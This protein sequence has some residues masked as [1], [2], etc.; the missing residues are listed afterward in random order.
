MGARARLSFYLRIALGLAVVVTGSMAGCSGDD[1][2]APFTGGT[3]GSAG[4]PIEAGPCQEGT[5]RP[6]GFPVQRQGDVVSCFRG[7][8]SCQSGT[9]G[10]CANGTVTQERHEPPP[11]GGSRTQALGPSVDCLNNPCDP[12]CKVYNETPDGGLISDVD[13]GVLF[14]WTS[15]SL[16]NV[17]TTL[18][19]KGL[20]QP[21]R[22]G[23]DC[24]FNHRCQD[25][26][27]PQSCGHSKCRTGS[28]LP[29]NCDPCVSMICAQDPSCC[30]SC[31]HSYCVEGTKLDPSCGICVA[32]VCTAMPSCCAAG[33]SWDAACVA[34][35]ATSCPT[36][37][38]SCRP[39]ELEF[40]GKC[41]IELTTGDSWTLSRN[42]CRDR[43]T[44]WDLVTIG[45]QA[46][47]AFVRASASGVETWIGY[48]DSA[49]EGS[50][51]WSNGEAS[52][53]Q[54]WWRHPDGGFNEDCIRIGTSGT[55]E[56]RD[57][58]SGRNSVC[59]KTGT[60]GCTAANIFNGN[61]Y[62]LNTNDLDWQDARTACQNH[63]AG[64]DLVSI[65]DAAENTFVRN[66]YVTGDPAWTGLNDIATENTFVWANGST[67]TYR[68][69]QLIEPNDWDRD[70]AKLLRDPGTLGDAF[71]Y[72]ENCSDDSPNAF[73]EGPKE[74]GWSQACVDRVKTTCDASCSTA[75]PPSRA[76][77]C[78]PWLPGQTD[79][80]CSGFD[81]AIGVPC[82]GGV[83]P[84]C[85]HGTMTAPA[86]VKVI[87]FRKDE[88][89]FGS[90]TPDQALRDD[91]DT[92][93]TTQPIEP[94]KCVNVTCSTL[95]DND[96]LMVNPP[97]ASQVAECSCLDNWSLYSSS[98]ACGAPA[99]SGGVSQAVFRRVNM[100]ISFDKS[101]S[102]A[103][104]RWDGSV[105]A[106]TSFF[107]DPATA[108]L[109]VALEYFGLGASLTVNGLSTGD[110]CPGASCGVAACASP[111]IPLGVLTAATG[112]ADPQED[113]LVRSLAV[114][115]GGST[116]SYPALRG[117]Y[118]AALARQA[119]APEEYNVVI[120]VTDGDPQD[121]QYMG[122]TAASTNQRLAIEAEQMYLNSEIPT[123]TICMTGANCAALDEIASRG[124]GDSF[125]IDSANTAQVA[126]DLK[127]A[128]L[129]IAGQNAS[130]VFELPN[131]GG[132]NPNAGTV[133]YTPSSG[134]TQSLTRQSSAATCGAGWY[135]DDPLN[136]TGITLCP[137][138][139][140]T[141]QAD[142]AAR[143]EVGLGCPQL[144]ASKMIT[145][146]YEGVCTQ[147]SG[148]QWGFLTY[149][150]TA[151]GDS[152]VRFQ[153]R[154]SNS[155]TDLGMAPWI[156]LAVVPPDPAV[157]TPGGPGPKCPVNLYEELSDNLMLPTN[158]RLKYVELGVTL[159]PT[160]N[161]RFSPT[162]ND[163]D[164]TYSCQANQ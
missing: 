99:C 162:L 53:Y 116:P 146:V 123:Y 157:C 148:P 103:G 122:G 21:C 68:N 80:T 108:G 41:Y 107:R 149:N 137:S 59:E 47:N 28:R 45:S 91:N 11:P 16:P 87:H 147:G 92:C 104:P 136:P 22:Y 50:W 64:F 17:P 42:N 75:D 76:G 70:C 13:A 48:S 65:D 100:F 102:M 140:S 96:E 54:N 158:A 89:A 44:G 9:W 85:N 51:L 61:C 27:T 23:A 128:L 73:C 155:L 152:N 35:V 143:I 117:A 74:S 139:C 56:D 83:V 12:F 141:I 133:L 109:G 26:A 129:D 81:L 97:G 58:N 124:G 49:T 112:T 7:T 164:I 94:G 62:W 66:T 126:A 3:G 29:S 160:S 118:N 20:H 105:Q 154:T 57:C 40:Q 52:T 55:W 113:I 88:A 4:G 131:V 125:T 77:V 78:V 86:G 82:A 46:E 79:T 106:L 34:Q 145:E 130:C 15:G 71:W 39:G 150:V 10:E 95:L 69:W 142:P 153:M 159:N 119:D 163:W 18:V 120:F 1:K 93:V 30:S 134:G 101:G 72:D 60:T 98:V 38:C 90:C 19:K 31:D 111:M 5:T 144:I 24:Q 36:A 156:D 32:A 115:T 67:A 151:P 132:F 121:C 25:V 63:G 8:Q 43:G 2:L 84:V 33:G 110:G 127:D 135:F 6:C 14:D 114:G 37:A 138:T 161:G